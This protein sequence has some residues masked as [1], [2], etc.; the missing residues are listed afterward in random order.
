M[1][2][3]PLSTF[4]KLETEI[5][6]KLRCY[7]KEAV[8]KISQLF[9]DGKR[10][11]LRQ[12][13]TGT[14]KSKEQ[15]YLAIQH[16]AA[17]E[18]NVYLFLIHKKELIDNAAQYFHQSGVRVSYLQQGKKTLW[19]TRVFL[20]SIGSMQSTRLESFKKFAHGKNLLIVCDETHHASAKTW[21]KVLDSFPQAKI[22]GFSATP[23]RLDGKGFDDIFEEII[24]G[25]DYQWYID[26]HFISPFKV[27]VPKDFVDFSGLSLTRGE[28]NTDEQAEKLEDN[29]VL[30][31]VIK[32]WEQ[33]ADG[34]KTVIF[35]P[36][37]YISKIVVEKLNEYS[38]KPFKRDIAAHLDGES[39]PDYRKECLER[40]RLPIDDPKS[41]LILSN[42]DLFSE[43]VDVPD[44]HVTYWLRKT[45]SPILNDQGNG[46]SNRYQEGK[47]QVIIDP[48]GNCLEHGL[49]NRPRSYSLEGRKKKEQKE[50]YKL[51]CFACQTV[52]TEDYRLVDRGK[53]PWLSCPTCGQDSSLPSVTKREKKKAFQ[54]NCLSCNKLIAEDFRTVKPPMVICDC[55]TENHKPQIWLDMVETEFVTLDSKHYEAINNQA[56]F[57]KYERYSDK[58]FLKELLK[59]PNISLALL[60]EATKYRGISEIYALAIWSQHTAKVRVMAL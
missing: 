59:L 31:D 13:F 2:S 47:T 3:Q 48:V 55:G 35:A 57:K 51:V 12:N 11:I 8:T 37:I 16:L 53:N 30:G 20:G 5:Y 17:S 22:V 19:N 1:Q 14:G 34:Q 46:R 4:Q 56:I 58:A 38:Q 18:N 60:T 9:N 15:N 50:K 29:Q 49:P 54:W 43:G 36:K 6:S 28:Y 32:T 10:S 52:I 45:K 42:V 7:Q 41:L 40:F 25:K 23:D 39:N 27:I 33:Y 24:E 26:N 44:C 21:K